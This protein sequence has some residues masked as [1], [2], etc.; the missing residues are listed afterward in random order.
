[1]EAPL[2]NTPLEAL[3][4]QMQQHGQTDLLRHWESLNDT[5]QRALYADLSTLDFAHLRRIFDAS[6]QVDTTDLKH[7]QPAQDVVTLADMSAMQ[8]KQWNATGLQLIA[9]VPWR[10]CEQTFLS[11]PSHG[12]IV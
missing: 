8:R 2:T 7:V 5:E 9:E 3:K 1:M 10:A 12:S 6:N 4:T 11:E